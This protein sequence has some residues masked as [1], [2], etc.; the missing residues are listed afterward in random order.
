MSFAPN[1]LFTT[2]G[3]REML[4]GENYSNIDM[5]FPFTT[6]FLGRALQNSEIPCPITIHALYSDIVKI[7][8]Y[9]SC[10][11]EKG[12]SSTVNL[13]KIVIHSVEELL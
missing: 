10:G 6:A 2:C 1:R 7:L 13:K 4:E 11:G 5:A 8:L 12:K 9:G 3:L